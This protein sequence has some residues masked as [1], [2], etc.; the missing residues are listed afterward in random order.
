MRLRETDVMV[1]TGV[2]SWMGYGVELP[3]EAG[4][5]PGAKSEPST[6]GVYA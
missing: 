2:A 4:D 1:A 6:H 5:P 3:G